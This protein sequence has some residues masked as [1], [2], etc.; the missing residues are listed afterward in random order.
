MNTGLLRDVEICANLLQRMNNMKNLVKLASIV[1]LGLIMSFVPRPEGLT[2]DAWIFFSLF[3]CVII[4]LI[5]EPF[6][7]AFIVLLGVIIACILKIG[8]ILAS[9]EDATASRVI[10][11]GLSGFSNTTVWLINIA[12]MFALGYEKTGLGKRIALILVSKMGK[13]TLGVGYAIAMSDLILAPFMPSNTARSGGTIFPIVKNVPILYGSTPEKEPRKIGAYITW[14]AFASTCVTSSMFYTALATNILAKSLLEDVGIMAPSWGQWFLNFLPVGI[15]LIFSVPIITYFA[16][17]PSIKIS[18]TIPE[19]ASNELKEMGKISRNEIV[20]TI[21]ACLA[22][23]LWIFGHYFG[24]HATLSA[25]V[26]LCLMVLFGIISWNDILMNKAAWNIFIWFGAMVTLAGGLN[27]VGFL[28]WF[29][30]KITSAISTYPPA[31]MLIMLLLVFYFIHY[32][33]A[34]SAA[35]VTALLIIFLVAGRNIAGID[36]SL[37]TYLFLYSLGLM[38]ILTPYATGASPIWYGLGYIPSKAFWKLGALFGIIF[39]AV[40]I[41]VGIPWIKLWI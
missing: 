15:I 2:Q 7:P 5:L 38:G 30:N 10:A 33:F 3:V 12:F 22:L 28:D 29:A 39:I 1:I 4:A 19:W 9:P 25:L 24:I 37:L 21:L 18:T 17:P 32:L 6:P 26:V 40:L 16:Y 8:P 14:V 41:L 11:W 13:S 20:M 27:N 23:L 35:H 34:S 36:F 31:L